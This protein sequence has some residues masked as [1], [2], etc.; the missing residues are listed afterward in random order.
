MTYLLDL[1]HGSATVQENARKDTHVDH[2]KAINLRILL[3][4][5]ATVCQRH[6]GGCGFLARLDA[7]TMMV[8]RAIVEGGNCGDDGRVM[9]FEKKV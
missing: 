3:L 6:A 9:G 5:E 8:V 7:D 2:D 4:V 1:Q